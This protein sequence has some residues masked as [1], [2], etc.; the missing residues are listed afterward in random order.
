[1]AHRLEVFF[2]VTYIYVHVTMYMYMDNLKQQLKLGLHS[3]ESTTNVAHTW[4]PEM[5]LCFVGQVC[6]WCTKANNS[7]FHFDLEKVE[8]SF[9]EFIANFKNTYKLI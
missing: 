8:E 2:I 6:S 9:F 1:M 5:M 4:I 7:K 3:S